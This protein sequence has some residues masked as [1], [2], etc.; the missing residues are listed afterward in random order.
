MRHHPT[1][2]GPAP[3][4]YLKASQ[5]G[6]GFRR[7][8]VI[9][10]HIVDSLA[11]SVRLVVEVDGG[12]HD[13]RVR[14][15]VGAGAEVGAGGY[16]AVVIRGVRRACATAGSSRYRAGA[17]AAA[18]GTGSAPTLHQRSSRARLSSHRSSQ[19]WLTLTGY[20]AKLRR[21]VI[22][23]S[24]ALRYFCRLCSHWD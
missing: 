23:S 19:S 10:A 1:R 17:T 8:L 13:E 22:M 4:Q 14:L 16:G 6:V 12:Y 18:V 20:A 15:D 2:P 11:P 21:R 7:Q 24:R 9:G 3:W 5:L